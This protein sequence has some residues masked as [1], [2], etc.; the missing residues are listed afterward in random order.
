VSN[1]NQEDS[2]KCIEAM[3]IY[4]LGDKIR[5]FIGSDVDVQFIEG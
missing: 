4:V 3:A 5:T 1:L 2:K